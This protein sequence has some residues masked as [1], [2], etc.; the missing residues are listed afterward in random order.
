MEIKTVAI[1]GAGAV[2]SYFIAGFSPYLN[3]NLWV[4]ADGERKARLEAEGI[5]INGK[6]YML[7]VKTPKQAKG[8]DLLLVALKY[9]SLVPALD[10]IK[11]IVTKD[12]IVMSLM[13]GVDSEEIIESV[14]GGGHM[15]CSMIKIAA[16][17][18]GSSVV[19]DPV[20]TQG[21]FFGEI[22]N[23]SKVTAIAKLCDNSDVK[24]VVCDDIMT[25]IWSK[26]ALN[27]SKNI[28]QAI[29][30]CGFGAYYDSAYVANM[31][32]LLRSEVVAVAAAKGI[33][34]SD[35]NTGVGNSNYVTKKARFSTLQ[36]LD[37][38]RHTEIDMFCGT[39]VKLG[40]ELNIPTPYNEFAYNII[41]GLEE[42]N[43]GR[44]DF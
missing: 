3:E 39:L 22:K 19:Y 36:D 42:K 10:E 9:N 20:A 28:P 44:F 6:K 11:E 24:Y 27:I 4:I 37:N 43:D 31:S 5:T 7:N 14:I 8:A 1:L 34:I 26:Y 12:T 30:G 17:R 25:A 32:R 29:I 33:D 41:K 35:E 21:V 23:T 40:S 18:I 2:G 13:N 15:V 16:E 38:H